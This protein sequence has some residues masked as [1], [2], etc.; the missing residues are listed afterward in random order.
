MKYITERVDSLSFAKQQKK[1]KLLL[2]LTCLSIRP[3]ICRDKFDSRCTD[4]RDG[5][6]KLVLKTVWLK[7][8]KISHFTQILMYT[9]D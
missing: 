6:L 1:K 8:D 9:Y 4:F 2:A 3:S 7:T 5:F